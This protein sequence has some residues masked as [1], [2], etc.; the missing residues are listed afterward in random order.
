MSKESETHRSQMLRRLQ[1]RYSKGDPPEVLEAEKVIAKYRKEKAE[2]RDQIARAS[3]PLQGADLCPSCWIMHGERNSLVAA[4]HP[5]PD[6]FDR[7]ICRKCSYFEDRD[8][9]SD[10]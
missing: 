6:K 9:R 5:D 3:T 1:N 2:S 7:M 8:A 10:P 4:N